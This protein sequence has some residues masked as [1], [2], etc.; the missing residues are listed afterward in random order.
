MKN[1]PTTIN[2]KIELNGIHHIGLNTANMQQA[3]KFYTDILGFPVL[4]RTRTKGGLQHIEV[5]AGNVAIAL[6]ES[7]HLD[8]EQGQKIMTQKGYLHFAFGAAKEQFESIVQALKENKV[9][10]DGELRN[11]AV[12]FFDPDGHQLEIHIGE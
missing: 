2:P 9:N 10:M 3:E 8:L 7:P 5:D 12:Y 4:M 1:D 6:F 11:N